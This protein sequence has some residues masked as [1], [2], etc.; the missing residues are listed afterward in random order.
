[1]APGTIGGKPHR[2]SPEIAIGWPKGSVRFTGRT[3]PA[4]WLGSPAAPSTRPWV[5]PIFPG[6][7][8]E[9]AMVPY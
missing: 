7:S 9:R 6:T 4:G 3:E 5:P 1:M 2:D 8:E